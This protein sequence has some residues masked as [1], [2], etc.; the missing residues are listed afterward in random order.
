MKRLAVLAL[1]FAGCGFGPAEVQSGGPVT[2]TVSQDFG[3]TEVAPVTTADVREGETV[4]RLL[5]RTLDVETRF[6]GN[7][8]QEIDGVAGGEADGKPVDWFFYV[9]GIEASEG[10]G[11]RTLYPGDRVWWDHHPWDAAMRIPAVVG[12]FPEPF[13]SGQMGKKFP[14]KLVCMGAEER[15]CDEVETRLR[16][17]GVRGVARSNLESSVG[18]VLRVLVGRWPELRKDIGARALEQGPAV[19]GVFAR[20]D[21]SGRSI[22]LLNAD[23]EVERTLEAGGGLVAAIRHEEYPPTWLVTGTDDVGVASA[24]AALTEEHLQNRFAVALED[25]RA[26]PLPIAAP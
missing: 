22:E 11:A 21:K 2:M 23:G 4:M 17:E 3:A 25:G 20:P 1:L 18:Q 15:S 16:D 7:F 13:R 6:G 24:A 10:A 5:Q 9:N 26:V 8:V 12:A 19:S 14:I